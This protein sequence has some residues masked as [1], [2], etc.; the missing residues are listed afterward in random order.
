M[1]AQKLGFFLEVD[2][3]R[4]G[5]PETMEV[6]AQKGDNRHLLKQKSPH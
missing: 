6:K 5:H 3:E 1:A 2:K 4:I